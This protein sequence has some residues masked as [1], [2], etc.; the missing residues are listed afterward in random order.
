[1]L[2]MFVVLSRMIGSLNLFTVPPEIVDGIKKISKNKRYVLWK[3]LLQEYLFPFSISDSS[4]QLVVRLCFVITI[5]LVGAYGVLQ[6]SLY[7]LR[8]AIGS[9]FVLALLR[10]QYA[11][12]IV[13]VL[14]SAVLSPN[15]NF[16]SGL[17]V[18]TILLLTSVPVKPIFQG[19]PQLRILLL[20]LLWVLAGIGISPIGIGGFLIVWLTYL[21]YFA[22]AILTI[23]LVTTRQRLLGLISPFE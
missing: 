15:I 11:L 12:L 16:L 8:V 22:I 17:T 9:I 3:T 4:R 6:N 14:I 13:W 21:D 19:V 10:Y 23:H 2:I 5:F 18:P 7:T 20:F 1:M